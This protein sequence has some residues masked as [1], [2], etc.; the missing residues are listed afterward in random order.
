MPNGG[1]GIWYGDGGEIS[2]TVEAYLAL[3]IA[4]FSPDDPR[5]SKAREFILARGGA[6][7]TRVFT[8]IFLA[9]FGQISWDGIPLLPVEFVLLPPGPASASMNSPVG[10]G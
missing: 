1:W 7:K 6:L 2:T 4:G 8:R 9:L 3:K 5:M 10:A